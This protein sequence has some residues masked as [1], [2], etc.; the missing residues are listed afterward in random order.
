MQINDY[1]P[2]EI[3]AWNYITVSKQILLSNRNRCL[4][5]YNCLQTNDYYP[6]EI[7]AWNYIT[8]LQTNDYY[9]IE[10]DVWNYITVS[11]QM[12]IIQQK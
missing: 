9:L 1:Y 11:K 4:K 7:D 12:I 2:I 8:V 10:I 6:I 5:L 3:N